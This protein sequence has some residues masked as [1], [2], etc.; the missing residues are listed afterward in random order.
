MNIL[1]Y[2]RRT[3]VSFLKNNKK[4]FSFHNKIQYST[5]T[6]GEGFNRRIYLLKN[7][8]RISPWHDIDLQP[9]A[10]TYSGFFELSFRDLSK[11]EVDAT[12]RHNPVKQD[13]HKSRHT[14][15]EVLRYYAKFPYVNYGMIPQT[16]EDSTILD[17]KT[18]CY[19]DNDPLDV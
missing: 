19:G 6:K 5:E 15:K 4:S 18:D 11:K 16:W 10:R 8:Q 17:P 1:T 2:T 9:S 12:T 7:N 3:T 13:T 14:G